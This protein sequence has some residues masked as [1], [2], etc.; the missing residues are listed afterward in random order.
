MDRLALVLLIGCTSSAMVLA[1]CGG[2]D[3]DDDEL[4]TDGDG[5]TDAGDSA[6]ESDDGTD[7][8]ESGSGDGGEE[9]G[10]SASTTNTGTTDTT[11]GTDGTDEG[12]CP[13]D[14]EASACEA[15]MLEACCEPLLECEDSE[16]CSCMFDC[17]EEGND[18]LACLLEC[19]LNVPG[20]IFDQLAGCLDSMCSRQCE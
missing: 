17:T 7:Q 10:G 3:S 4:G 13:D 19:G 12:A 15:C 14:P 5:S 20:L 9:G 6:D 11:E 8:G 1:A 16:S 18:Q 2:D